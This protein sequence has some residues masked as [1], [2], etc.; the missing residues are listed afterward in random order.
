MKKSLCLLLAILTGMIPALSACGSGEESANDTRA[1]SEE[2]TTAVE[3]DYLDS[4]GAK[5]FGGQTFVIMDAN[6]YPDSSINVTWDEMNGDLVNDA[7]VSRDQKIGE[8]YN[9][10]IE[11]SLGTSAADSC[12]KYSQAYLAGDKICDL[13]YSRAAATDTFYSLVSQGMLADLADNAYINLENPWWNR[14]VVEQ[15]SLDGRLYF[16]SGD[17]MPAIYTSPV[18]IGAN[19]NLLEQYTPE[20]DIYQLVVD[21]KWTIDELLAY[22]KYNN[23]LDGDNVMHTSHDFFG[24]V[25]DSTG[26]A[27]SAGAFAVGC[28]VDLCTVNN[29]GL[30]INLTSEHAISVVEKLAQLVPHEKMDDRRDYIKMTFKEDRSIFVQTYMS[31]FTNYL[32]D[33]QSDYLILPMPKYDAEQ[34]DYRCLMNAWGSCFMAIPGNAD[35]DTSGFIAEALCYESYKSVRPAIYDKVLKQ[36]A[37]RD[38]RS[39]AMIDVIFDGLYVDFN[40]LYDF[41]G[42][43]TA[44]A[45]AVYNSSP[46]VSSVAAKQE[47]INDAVE[48][49][50]SIW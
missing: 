1:D 3:T 37:A 36:K 41:G 22:T 33:M 9:V 20:A 30:A 2:K 34:E 11:Y 13:I 50:T 14:L 40:A 47:A 28:G 6:D 29:D 38:E 21:G 43:T 4:L 39:T 8:R 12:K 24:Y 46:L 5:N 27:L 25:G 32:R 35:E 15:L 26:N 18:V 23:D 42:V 19:L 31:S 16:T 48:K 44:L 7:M 49:L 45:N 17:I 10:T